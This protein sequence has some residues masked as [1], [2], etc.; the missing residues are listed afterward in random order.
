M[1]EGGQVQPSACMSKGWHM[2]W[3]AGATQMKTNTCQMWVG[4]AQM[5]AGVMK[6]GA[7]GQWWV[8][9]ERG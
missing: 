7:D 5:S 4:T 8:P 1:N 2:Q 9:Y 6:V 3:R